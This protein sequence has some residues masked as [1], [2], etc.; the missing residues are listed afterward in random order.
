MILF[1][2]HSCT[3]P[4]FWYPWENFYCVRSKR[5]SLPW[6]QGHIWVLH[7]KVAY[8]SLW[9]CP[10][11]SV[12]QKFH[13]TGTGSGISDHQKHSYLQRICFLISEASFWPRMNQHTA[14]WSL[15]S[16][17]TA[18]SA[19]PVDK[20][21]SCRKPSHPV[22]PKDAQSKQRLIHTAPHWHFYSRQR[23]YLCKQPH[24]I[25]LCL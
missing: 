13:V 15:P 3:F 14:C 17:N 18:V 7:H 24:L 2:E 4:L 20:H 23:F 10:K 9:R 12:Y 21:T 25:A 8:L 19:I 5:L 16:S 11:I 6:H 1:P 22:P